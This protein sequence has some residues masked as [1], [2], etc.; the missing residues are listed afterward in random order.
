VWRRAFAGELGIAVEMERGSYGVFKVLVDG[1]V[2]IDGGGLAALGVLPTGRK[3]V[4]GV[5]ERLSG[6]GC[7]WRLSGSRLST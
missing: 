5:R 7:G 6:S 3:V 1:D 2:V 4:E